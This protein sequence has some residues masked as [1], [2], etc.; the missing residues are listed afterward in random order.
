[1]NSLFS[2]LSVSPQAAAINVSASSS[3][4]QA[5]KDPS[6]LTVVFIG[7]GTVFLGRNSIIVISIITSKNIIII[8]Y[9]NML[10]LFHQLTIIR[11]RGQCI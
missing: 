4:A 8:Y 7:L 11:Y 6:V 3:A 1:M 9:N 10:L 5:A 2:L